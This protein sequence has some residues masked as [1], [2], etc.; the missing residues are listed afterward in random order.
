MEAKKFKKVS[1]EDFNVTKLRRL[2]QEGKLYFDAND[3]EN[4]LTDEDR[5][6][7]VLDY[8]KEIDMKTS[9]EFEPFVK[10]IWKKIVFTPCLNRNLF[11][12]KGKNR[13]KLNRY[14]IMNLVE[15]LYNK[16]VYYGSSLLEL[17]RLLEHVDTRNVIYNSYANYSFSGEQRTCLLRLLMEFQKK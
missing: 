9:P 7:I 17:H 14:T 10:E 3:T 11:H 2:A 6:K 16:N 4:E 1:P 5:L 8:V 13:G 15:L 12:V